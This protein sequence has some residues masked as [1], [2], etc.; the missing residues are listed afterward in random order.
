MANNMKFAKKILISLTI[1]FF[2]ITINFI[3]N[4]SSYEDIYKNTLISKFKQVNSEINSIITTGVNFGKP[5]YKFSNIETYFEKIIDENQD[6]KNVFIISKAGEVLYS[7]D[8]NYTDR[9]IMDSLLI[10]ENQDMDIKRS[11]GRYFIASPIIANDG[12]VKGYVYIEFLEKVINDETADMISEKINV[13]MIAIVISGLLL[14]G[15]Y[16][17]M[18]NIGSKKVN[19]KKMQLIVILTL[20]ISQIGYTYISLNNFEGQYINLLN[21]NLENFS[22]TIKKEIDYYTNLGLDLDKLKG[23]EDYLSKEIQEV[24]ECKGVIISGSD[25]EVLYYADNTGETKSILEGKISKDLL[26]NIKDK[27]LIQNKITNN[28][29]GNIYLHINEDLIKNKRFDLFLDTATVLIIS[30]IIGYQMLLLSNI[31]V[32]E[33]IDGRFKQRINKKYIIQILAFLFYFAEMLPLS[34]IA[35]YIRDTY[36]KNTIN[37]FNLSQEVI[38]GIPIASYMLGAAISVLV[39]GFLASR[40]S[41]K[42]ILNYCILFLISGAIGAALSEDIMRLTIFRM[43]SGFGYGGMS[44]ISTSIILE[45]FKDKRLA[46]GFGFWASGYGAASLCAVPIGGV[47]VFR[48]GYSAALIVSAIISFFLLVFTLIYFRYFS[49]KPLEI[50]IKNK[51][52]TMKLSKILNIF[53]DKK[54]FAN[55][56]FRLLPFH[57]VY[58]GIFQFMIPLFMSKEGVSQA[59]IGR[60]LTI[61]GLVYLGM[62]LISKLVDRVKNDKLFI[63][64]GNMI[65]GL[66]LLLIG[67]SSNLII[68]S[69]V[70]LGISVGSMIGDAAEE[71]FITSTDKAK[72]IGKTKFMSIYN[73]YERAIMVI[74]PLISSVLVGFFGYSK[75]IFIIGVYVI[76]STF[77]YI[78]LL[79]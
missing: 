33:F 67:I 12:L 31:K 74:A 75:S 20:I 43:L 32:N 51:D 55:Y 46:T 27:Y 47:I 18:K 49:L 59:N 8:D 6:I 69:L 13:F 36:S 29:N 42:R 76:M 70:I 58:I 68:F 22:R 50:K 64:V 35:L 78:F 24:P 21:D 40:V 44:I 15:L 39:A 30:I 17:F 71:S 5:L 65:I 11:E 63:M 25:D 37:I 1:I 62:P 14:I 48:F 16:F 77:I 79:Y 38:F 53:N 56:F 23:L 60:M 45:I 34:F 54:V 9:Y 7:H 72:E 4:I 41:K 10:N 28:Q 57:I 19:I 52:K 26:I 3:L 61:F 66:C 2:S 73:S